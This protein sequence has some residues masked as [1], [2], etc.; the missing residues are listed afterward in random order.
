MREMWDEEG[1]Q[2]GPGLVMESDMEVAGCGLIDWGIYVLRQLEPWGARICT[3]PRNHKH[4][5]SGDRDV[6]IQTAMQCG[7]CVLCMNM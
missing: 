3:G 6:D 5:Y 2:Q 1:A 7:A 4:S